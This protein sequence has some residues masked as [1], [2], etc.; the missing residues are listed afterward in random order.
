MGGALTFQKLDFIKLAILLARKKY[1][2]LAECLVPMGE[3]IGMTN[4]ELAE[5]LR[6]KT[7]KFTK[8]EVRRAYMKRERAGA[9]VKV[10]VLAGVE[11]N[12]SGSPAARGNGQGVVEKST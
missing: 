9:R 4:D 3:Q 6:K 11:K 5:M 2:Y 7:R 8:D 12:V 10:G 1:A